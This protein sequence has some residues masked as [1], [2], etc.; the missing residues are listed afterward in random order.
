MSRLN[1]K[2]AV[3]TGGGSGIGEAIA[4]RFGQEG[5]SVAILDLNTENA[6]KVAAEIESAG[7]KAKAFAC[8][9]ADSA[10]VK[11]VF[12]A[13]EKE[14]GGVTTL[15]NNAGIAHIGKVHETE[16]ED[17]DKI[18]NVNIKGVYNC[19][20]TAVKHF[21][22][23]GGGSIV[24][25]ASV[26]STMGIPDRFAYSTSKG[27]VYMMTKSVAVDYLENNIRCNCISPARVHTPFVDG[28]LAKTYPG[29]EKEMF[30]KLS[31]TQPIG[32]MGQPEE[33]AS[34]ALFLASDEAGFITGSDYLIDGGFNNLKV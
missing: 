21:L 19:L 24:N 28:Y 4:R 32:R 9:V 8:N 12:K 23:N 29:Q 2:V 7:G 11:E 6:D 34:L 30:E 31:K 17:L 5:A 20:H 15:V 26:A 33:I 1:G 16:P 3:V 18:Y 13:V 27:A 10:N 22:N 25:M 14:F